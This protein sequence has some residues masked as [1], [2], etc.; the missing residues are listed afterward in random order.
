MALV[1]PSVTHALDEGLAKLEKSIQ[2][3]FASLEKRWENS[4]QVQLLSQPE[5]TQETTE[6]IARRESVTLSDSLC[7]CS[8]NRA[9]RH[10]KSCFRSFQHKKVHIIAGKF[11]TFNSLLQVKLEVQRAP[12]A[13][14]RDLKVYPNFSMRSMVKEYESEAFSLVY[15]TFLAMEPLPSA[16]DLAKVFRD[17][18]VGLRKL[19]EERKAW[20]TDITT[21]GESLLH[22]SVYDT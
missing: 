11:R 5:V 20:P 4:D 21:Y 18:L 15:D 19:F 6:I 8:I 22:V 9:Q 17:C 12:F 2:Q 14:A 7:S 13:F 10:E 16:P 3:Q 1:G